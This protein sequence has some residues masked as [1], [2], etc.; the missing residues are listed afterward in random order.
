MTHH[1]NAAITSGSIGFAA[2]HHHEEDFPD[3]DNEA[4]LRRLNQGL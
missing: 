2:A 1:A 4:M 3:L